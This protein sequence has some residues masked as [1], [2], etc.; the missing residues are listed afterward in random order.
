M[1]TPH[2]ITPSDSCKPAHSPLPSSQPYNAQKWQTEKPSS[3]HTTPFA[4]AKFFTPSPNSKEKVGDRFIPFRSCTNLYTQFFER[5]AEHTKPSHPTSEHIKENENWSN[6]EKEEQKLENYSNLLETQ[7]FEEYN[8]PPTK[9]IN[10]SDSNS[11]NSSISPNLMKK[12][13]VIFKSE[14][15]ENTL[16]P[17]QS[18]PIINI[19]SHLFNPPN[20]FH[21]KVPQVPFKI[22]DAPQLLDDFYLNLVDWS[23]SNLLAVGLANKVYIWSACTSKVSLL[24]EINSQSVSGPPFNS[25][26]EIVPNPICSVG[27]NSRGNLLCVG[28][29]DGNIQ[30][31]DVN[32]SKLLRT[33]SGHTSRVSSCAWSNQLL[34]TG[35]NLDLIHLVVI[36]LFYRYFIFF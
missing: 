22:L 2:K 7:M 3:K 31:W 5:D 34:S 24:C 29:N 8:S 20:T 19:S 35:K 13:M 11:C 18:S 30:I 15:K 16:S 36:F 21:R 4:G 14:K 25:L 17:Y 26:T 12:N 1:S 32:Q 10:C 9:N 27:W 33:I 28:C 6:S 23:V